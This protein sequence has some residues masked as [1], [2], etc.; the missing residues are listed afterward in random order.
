[1]FHA[2]AGS[3]RDGGQF[4]SYGRHE[5]NGRSS[6]AFH[7]EDM[8]GRNSVISGRNEINGRNSVASFR[9]DPNGRSS[10]ASDRNGRSSVASGNGAQE[11]GRSSVVSGVKDNR[12]RRSSG[13]GAGSHN[14]VHGSAASSRS[15]RSHISSMSSTNTS[16]PGYIFMSYQWRHRALME[17]VK[18]WLEEAGIKVSIDIDP[19]T[20]SIQPPD[21]AS[22]VGAALVVIGLSSKYKENIDCEVEA[23]FAQRMNKRVIFLQLEEGYTGTSWLKPMVQSNILLD[24]TKENDMNKMNQLMQVIRKEM[25]PFNIRLRRL[26]EFTVNTPLDRRPADVTGVLGLSNGT[27]VVIDKDNNLLKLFSEEGEYLSSIYNP[28]EAW[29][30]TSVN[31]S[32]FATCGLYDQKVHFW[33]VEGKLIRKT[34]KLFSLTSHAEGIHFNGRYFVILHRQELKLSLLSPNGRELGQI[35]LNRIDNGRLEIG[36]DLKLDKDQDLI[37]IPVL[38]DIKGVLCIEFEFSHRTSKIHLTERWRCP[39]LG[40]PSTIMKID[41]VIGGSDVICA[42]DL[43]TKS[44]EMIGTDE[45]NRGTLLWHAFLEGQPNC[46]TGYVD[47][48]GTRKFLLSYSYFDGKRSHITIF[49]FH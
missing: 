43:T 12:D 19:R 27:I 42:T 28:Q 31:G 18:D 26:K 21:Q 44:V 46:I 20:G 22:L 3:Q 38:K 49:R 17:G 34:D 30:I 14:S 6:A 4:D 32:E 8:N 29:G 25:K 2:S 41:G 16:S 24:F 9:N 45:T 47:S 13:S 10:V 35:N 23:K 48:N 1:M 36:R 39:L 37:Y 11:N 33:K 7:R 15:S 5:M 40:R